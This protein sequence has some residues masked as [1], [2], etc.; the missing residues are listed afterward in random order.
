MDI[1]IIYLV[2]NHCICTNIIYTHIQLIQFPANTTSKVWFNWIMNNEHAVLL[3]G[4]LLHLCHFR[5]TPFTTCYNIFDIVWQKT[6]CASVCGVVLSDGADW[7]AR[8]KNCMSDGKFELMVCVYAIYIKHFDSFE[9][10]AELCKAH[11][12]WNIGNWLSFLLLSFI[13]KFR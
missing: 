7:C 5:K 3:G 13:D 10:A 6:L 1:K 9:L 4:A 2:R 12:M 11:T 8:V